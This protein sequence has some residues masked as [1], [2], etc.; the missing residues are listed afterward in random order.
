MIAQ[1]SDTSS[2]GWAIFSLVSLA[3]YVFYI[4]AVWRAFE[5]AGKPGWA[6][7]VPI[8]NFYIM[9]KIAGRPGWWW[10]LLRSRSS[11]S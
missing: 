11:T 8:Y 5:K 3:V 1:Y 9:C 2:G 7:I 6:A 4:V 10:V